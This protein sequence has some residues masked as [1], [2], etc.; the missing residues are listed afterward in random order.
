[1]EFSSYFDRNAD[2][3]IGSDTYAHLWTPIESSLGVVV[4]CMPNLMPLWTRLR[5]REDTRVGA[6]RTYSKGSKGS[7]T[8]AG[9]YHYSISSAKHIGQTRKGS[10]DSDLLRESIKVAGI[11]RTTEIER[12]V[13]LQPVTIHE[14]SPNSYC[15]PSA[16]KDAPPPRSGIV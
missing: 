2:T 10:S 4:A 9:S 11:M 15:T 7:S 8:L 5:G 3:N 12:H 13:E 6:S 1:M 16:W 14:S